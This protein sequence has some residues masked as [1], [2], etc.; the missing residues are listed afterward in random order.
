MKYIQ[1][2][3]QRMIFTNQEIIDLKKEIK[4]LLTK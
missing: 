2:K 1:Y 3:N 4:T